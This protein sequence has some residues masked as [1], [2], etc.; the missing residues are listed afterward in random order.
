MTSQTLIKC[1]KCGSPNVYEDPLIDRYVCY[2]CG[3]KFTEA[4]L[5]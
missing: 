4:D 1:P 2:K 3:H 5:E